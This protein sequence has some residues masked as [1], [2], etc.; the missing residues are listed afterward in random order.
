MN[1]DDTSDA[2][3]APGESEK[4]IQPVPWVGGWI[5]P[6]MV[7][8]FTIFW[9]LTIYWLVGWRTRDWQYGTV[10]YVPAESTFTTQ[11]HGSGKVPKQVELPVRP[12][13]GRNAAIGE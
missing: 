3:P 2:R 13:G 4:I 10:P 8:L 7:V 1:T 11:Q 6:T 5:A 12:T 9:A